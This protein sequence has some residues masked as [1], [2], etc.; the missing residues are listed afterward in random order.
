MSIAVWCGKL[1]VVKYLILEHNIDPKGTPMIEER[2]YL[3]ER[4][5]K[6]NILLNFLMVFSLLVIVN[7]YKNCT[8]VYNTCTLIT[9]SLYFTPIG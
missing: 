9:F 4:S 6:R 1:L 5:K 8:T 3:Y 2:M 7:R